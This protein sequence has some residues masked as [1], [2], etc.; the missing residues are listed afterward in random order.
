MNPE[1]KW[2]LLKTVL[3]LLAL[4]CVFNLGRHSVGFRGDEWGWAAIIFYS[5]VCFGA[6]LLPLRDFWKSSV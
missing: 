4:S 6:L 2:A 5:V 1:R 3:V